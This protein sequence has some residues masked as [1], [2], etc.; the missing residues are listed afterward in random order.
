MEVRRWRWTQHTAH[1]LYMQSNTSPTVQLAS[2][3][4]AFMMFGMVRTLSENDDDDPLLPSRVGEADALT[5]RTV[6]G[7]LLFFPTF[8]RR[9][10]WHH[11][12]ARLAA[13]GLAGTCTCARACTVDPA[14]G[15]CCH[16]T[17]RPFLSPFTGA[18]PHDGFAAAVENVVPAT[19]LKHVR[20]SL[21]CAHVRVLFCRSSTWQTCTTAT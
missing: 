12:H 15:A 16:P 17:R 3:S 20:A 5:V 10:A 7:L 19:K 14:C 18:L 8:V 2:Q 13:V 21:H 6:P 11:S 1:G 4:P 9:H